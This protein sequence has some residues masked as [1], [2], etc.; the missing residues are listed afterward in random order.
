LSREQRKLAHCARG[1]H[2]Y[3]KQRIRVARMMQK[4][5]DQRH[6]FQHKLSRKLSD[7]YNLVCI[8]DLAIKRLITDTKFGKSAY[9]NG[10]YQFIQMLTYKLTES[11]KHLQK[12]G[13]WF[14]STRTCSQCGRINQPL[15]LDKRIYQCQCGYTASRDVNAAINIKREGERLYR[16][17]VNS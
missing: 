8:E 2:N 15:D 1:S 7:Q 14:P 9:D 12:V 16:K 11:Y 17:R 10:W 4:C 6:D 5:A 3:Q 13:R